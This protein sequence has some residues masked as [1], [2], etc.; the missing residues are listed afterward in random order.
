MADANP[1]KYSD[2]ISPDD[3]IEK[4]IGQ[5]EELN[6]AY[7]GMA[8]SVKSQA[9]G[10]A[11][12]LAKVSG[13]TISGQKATKEA[14]M[15]A[16]RLAK[17]YRELEFAQTNTA[18]K[19]Q[20]LRTL[21]N[22]EARMTKLQQQLNNAAAGS[23]NQLS[24]QYSLNKLA[25]NNLTKAEREN[26]PAAKKLI[27]DTRRIYEEMNKMQQA[28]GKFSLNV[29][30]YEQ[31]ITNAIGINTKWYKGIQELGALF[32][33][34]FAKG[35]STAGEAVAAFGKKLLALMMNP[36]VATIAAITAAFMALAKGISTSEENTNTLMR[37]LAPFERILTG[38][39]DGLQTMA[40]W[41]LKGVEGM[42]KL[43]MGAS[44]LMERLPLVGDSIKKVNA[45]L[46]E[47]IDLTR[48]KQEL[49][50]A[51]RQ[52][53]VTQA[54]LARNVAKWRRDAEATSDPK[55]RATL[56]KMAMAAEERMMVNEI[57]LAKEDLRIQEARAAQ[58]QND[59]E[60][61]E[62]LAQARARLMRAEENYYQRTTRLQSKLRKSEEAMN[63]GGKTTNGGATEDAAK[64]ELEETRKLEDAR[65]ALIEDANIR[66][67]MTIVA[68]YNRKIEDLKGSEE[69]I[70]QMRVLLEE[71]KQQKLAELFEKEVK[72]QQEKDKKLKDEQAKA[73]KDQEQAR[74]NAIRAEEKAINDQYEY[75]S[76]LAELEESENKKTEMRLQAEKKRLQALLAL[77]EKDGKTLTATEV[78]TI[79]NSIAAVDQELQKNKSKRD[80]FDLMGFKLND[81]QK[82][83]I[84]ESLEFALDSVNTFIEA[85]AQAAEQKRQLADAEVDRAQS[86]LEKEIEAR[87]NGYA[88]EVE[89][90]RK[91]L[92]TAKKNQQKAI[93]QEKRAQQAKE[94]IDTATQASSLITAT[95][96]IWS[97]L[98]GIPIVGTA[99]ALAAIATMWGSFA[100]A[101]IK[102]REVTRGGD[103]EYGEGTVELLQGGSHQS[104]NDI[105]LGRKADGTRRRA[106]GG[107]FFAVI[108]KRNSRKY[109]GV[110][111]DVVNSLNNGTFAE[112]YM[113]A[114]NG[115]DVT[116][117]RDGGTNL[118][119][120]ERGIDRI[121][122]NLEKPQVYTDESGNIVMRYKNLTKI[123]RK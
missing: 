116:F 36:V 87:A 41:L 40:G 51:E 67:R 17:A 72:Q 63:K 90:A 98:S 84:N 60:T 74:Q 86:V 14:S 2:L 50:K 78:A 119:K 93:E 97:S 35:L 80:F 19:I 62:K 11:A 39:I 10:V 22:E 70:M 71:Q 91:E 65:I 47:N 79:K 109:R 94:M 85:Y 61:N 8:D 118:D 26:D 52:N 110:I 30:N 13:A 73:A 57:R 28:T 37:I 92:E 18:K 42:E 31:S 9:A 102:A 7:T 4:L 107:E 104:G 3:S 12:S 115:G 15:E 100:A 112:K 25:I 49:D 27:E 6:K 103:E 16:D 122:T 46:Q 58:S 96:N 69:Y 32:E 55:R 89:T 5:L 33:G 24:A 121:N 108:N 111:P 68:S 38:I 99:L 117:Y 59:A 64:K 20:E 82:E 105:D 43:A 45:A 21:R 77:Y 44:K 75:D 23:Y 101:K 66:E 54:T 123:I 1:I 114:Y 81:E 106:E 95:A 113:N 53:T 34:G 83:A 29:G 76:S 88:N 56:L 120:V 48:A